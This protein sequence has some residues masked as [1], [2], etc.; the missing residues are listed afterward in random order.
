LT[1]KQLTALKEWN[2]NVGKEMQAGL[3]NDAKIEFAKQES[4]LKLE[5]GAA[6]EKN[7]GTGK[8]AVAKLGLSKDQVD[9][10]Q[11]ALGYDG[12]LKLMAQVGAGLGEGQFVTGDK[13]RAGGDRSNVMTP[14]Q[15]KTELKRLQS[16]KEFQDAWMNAQHP[17]HKEMVEKK[18]QLSKW[19]LGQN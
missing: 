13:G 12:V 19:S 3:E 15:A 5:W 7:L 9:A 8:E 10:M 18:S 4:A 11:M 14:E 6:Y 1:T 17:R 2:D 16:D